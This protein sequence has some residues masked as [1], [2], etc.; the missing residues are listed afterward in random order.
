MDRR[1]L[2]GPRRTWDEDAQVDALLA[3]HRKLPL[4]PERAWAT[5]HHAGDGAAQ[6]LGG[7]LVARLL[8]AA[9]VLALAGRPGEVG[10]PDLDD[11]SATDRLE[12][13]GRSGE[14]PAEVTADPDADGDDEWED[15]ADAA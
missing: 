1:L 13:D 12:L 2:T 6:R 7:R 11:L 3:C 10:W 4:D 15:D 8:A 9:G 5:A 14:A